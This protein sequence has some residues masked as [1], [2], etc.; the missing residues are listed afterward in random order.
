MKQVDVRCDIMQRWTDK[1]CSGR[2]PSKWG[3]TSYRRQ[4]WPKLAYGLGTNDATIKEIEGI[5]DEKGD[6]QAK[7][8]Q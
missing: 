7:E 2:L 8:W 4:L 3:W 1:L 6:R 5:E